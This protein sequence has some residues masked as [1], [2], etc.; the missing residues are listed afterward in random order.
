MIAVAT[1]ITSTLVA[2]GLTSGQIH[3]W[4]AGA[5][6]ELGGMSPNDAIRIIGP[7]AGQLILSLA[8]DDADEVREY[9]RAA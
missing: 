1:G 9:R 4:F 5:R 3:A 2:A 8:R 6:A 7:P